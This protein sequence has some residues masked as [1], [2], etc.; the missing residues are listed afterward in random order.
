MNLWLF[1]LFVFL[2]GLRLG[3]RGEPLRRPDLCALRAL[4]NDSCEVCSHDAPLVFYGSTRPFLCH[5]FCD[6]L[7]VHTTVKN[8][9]CNLSRVLALQK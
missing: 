2:L 4:G 1:G 9:P 3:D 8:S 6:T 5:L 7:L